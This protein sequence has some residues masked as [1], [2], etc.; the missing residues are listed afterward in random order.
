M[1]SFPTLATLL[2]FFAGAHLCRWTKAS[3]ILTGV[4]DGPLTGGLPKA[5]ELYATTDTIIDLSA[6]QIVTY[7]NGAPTSTS[8]VALSDT[9]LAAGSFYYLTNDADGFETFF[10]FTADQEVL[11]SSINANGD[12]V[13]ELQNAADGT[14]VDVHGVVGVDG[15]DEPWEFLDGWAYRV[16]GTGPEAT[17]RLASW[18]YSGTNALD[19]ETTNSGARTPFPIGTYVQESA[20]PMELVRIHEIQGD[21]ATSPL[22]GETVTVEAV[23]VGDFQNGDADTSRNLGGFFVQ[24]EDTDIDGDPLTS[25]GIFVYEGSAS[26]LA[27]VE[28]GDLVQSHR[29]SRRVLFSDSNHGDQH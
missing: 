6:Y 2:V 3:L 17:F 29:N 18:I 21:G 1:R 9:S 23:V 25:E 12:D 22:E 8:T 10:G 5:V 13:Y 16:D 14:V 15:T 4:V 11:G 20:S 26:F 19:G 7:F 27:D 28:I 24:E